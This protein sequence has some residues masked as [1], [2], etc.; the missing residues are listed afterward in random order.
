MPYENPPSGSHEIS[1]ET[2]EAM[3]RRY[4]THMEQVLD[5]EYRYKEVLAI[6]ETFD[7]SVLKGL[8]GVTGAA[9]FRIYYGMSEDLKVHAILVAVDAEGKDILPAAPKMSIEGDPGGGVLYEDSVRCPTTCPP[10]SSLNSP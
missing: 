3:T 2:A 8:Q 7:L 1:L 4:R 9:A 5:P 6:C 10:A